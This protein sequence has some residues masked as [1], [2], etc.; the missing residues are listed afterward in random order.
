LGNHPYGKFPLM[1]F[2]F[3]VWAALILWMGFSTAAWAVETPTNVMTEIAFTAHRS[4]ADPFNEVTLDAVFTDPHGEKLRVPAFWDGGNSW[5]V[6][7]ASPLVGTHTFRTECSDAADD[8]LNGIEGR[9]EVRPYAGTNPLYLHGPL[10]VSDNH[11]YLEYF[12][13]TP[14]FWLGDTW[15]MGLSHR[16]HFPDEFGRLAADRMAKGFNVIQIVAGLYPDMPPFDPRGANEAGFPWEADF[17]SIRPEYFDEADKRLEYLVD[18]GL[19][20]CLVGSWGYFMR[21]MGPK[22]LKAHWRNLIAR[23]GALPV[24]WCA[25]GEVSMGFYHERPSDHVAKDFSGDAIKDWTQVM[26]YLRT[27]DPFHRLITVH[28][29]GSGSG[30]LEMHD[31]SL[32]DF[33]ML[34]TGHGESDV[35]PSTVDKVRASYACQPV[36][37][38]IIG[39][40]S[41]E[42]LNDSLPTE[43]TRRMFWLSLMNGAAGHT[44]GANGIWQNNRT[45]DPHGLSPGGNS[46]GKIPWNEAMNLP[47]SSQVGYGKR[48]FLQYPWQKFEPHPEWASF[49]FIKKP[50]P[51]PMESAN[52]IWYP[53]GNP[54]KD[55]PVGKRFFRRSF[56]LLGGA[57]QS[58]SLRGFADDTFTAS[59]N[60]HLLGGS[61]TTW[62]AG[63]QFD[64][65][66]HL[67]KPGPNL[68]EITA[69]NL[70]APQANPA[71]LLSLLEIT[72]AGSAPLKIVSDGTW[73]CTK[74]QQNWTKALVETPYGGGP[75]GRVAGPDI[76]SP[77]GAY[78]PQSTGIPGVVRLTYV[79]E[80]L[81]V[82]LH[83]LGANRSYSAA[84]FDPVSGETTQKGLMRS[85]AAG[86]LSCVSPPGCDH[87]WVVILEKKK[88]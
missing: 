73:E 4:H 7:Y 9:V 34:Q 45:G 47:G 30:R 12:D 84:Y 16:L 55:A 54:S 3:C 5:K 27:T 60:G 10:R 13:G 62:Q 23:Y 79:P 77:E 24:V 44:Y 88:H 69:E 14:F 67:L 37:P 38:V 61:T 72:I 82:V 66:T 21:F 32:L 26:S 71:G 57:I 33:D 36:M 81:G 65:L 86:A 78:G 48:L 49:D 83:D 11:R 6:R 18:H 22:D 70:P 40:V 15:W 19:T 8:G 59:L 35:V 50:A 64:D 52:W 1:R 56:I 43:W 75:W 76:S 68:L 74:D 58:A 29:S 42:M 39:E 41:Y 20:P 2:R 51:V 46:W 80:N 25:A 85:D 17:K 53:E 87:D 63:K 31:P 28:P